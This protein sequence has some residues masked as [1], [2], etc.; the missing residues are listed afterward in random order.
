MQMQPGRVT[1]VALSASDREVVVKIE[2]EER[3]DPCPSG[4]NMAPETFEPT[5]LHTT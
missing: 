5:S 2:N 4:L 1:D 3:R